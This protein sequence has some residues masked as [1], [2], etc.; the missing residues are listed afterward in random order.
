MPKAKIGSGGDGGD[1][2]G[3]GGDA[4]RQLIATMMAADQGNGGAAVLG[5][6]DDRR[7]G[8]LVGKQRGDEADENAGST[9]ADERAAGGEGPNNLIAY[10]SAGGGDVGVQRAGQPFGQRPGAGGEGDEQRAGYH[11]SL[12]R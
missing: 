2:A 4:A 6:G 7:F 1:A 9:D 12:P 5:H 8:L 10:L 11:G 3:E